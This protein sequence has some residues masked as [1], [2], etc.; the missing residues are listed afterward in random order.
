MTERLH[1]GSLTPPKTSL[2]GGHHHILLSQVPEESKAEDHQTGHWP[3]GRLHQDSGLQ[4]PLCS[5][6]RW[7]LLDRGRSSRPQSGQQQ[8][9][10]GV[11]GAAS[12]S[13]LSHHLATKP[14]AA[15]HTIAPC[16]PRTAGHRR[17]RG[18]TNA[19]IAWLLYKPCSLYSQVVFCSFH[20]SLFFK[21]V[22]LLKA[23]KTT[24]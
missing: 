20:C 15:N 16:E 19:H 11:C 9:W 21:N 12:R 3:G 1:R 18:L 2:A 17:G 5:S 13:G 23:E 8:L 22:S 10:T 7:S 4:E 6:S 24:N 14:L